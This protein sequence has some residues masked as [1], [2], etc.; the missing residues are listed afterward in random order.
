MSP[1]QR[2]NPMEMPAA[3]ASCGAV[4]CSGVAGGI[5]LDA[6]RG[7]DVSIMVGKGEM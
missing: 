3:S 2:I 7:I 1:T 4:S 6:R 5:A